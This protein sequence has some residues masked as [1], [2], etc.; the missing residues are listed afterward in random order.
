MSSL[1]VY[2]KVPM[3][4]GSLRTKRAGPSFNLH[5]TGL[6]PAK[7]FCCVL[8]TAVSFAVTAV[9]AVVDDVEVV[10]NYIK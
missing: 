8:L 4:C 3:P 7:C 5:L 9:T 10:I 6:P 1:N 2:F